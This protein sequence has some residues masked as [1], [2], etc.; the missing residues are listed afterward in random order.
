M[1]INRQEK[2]I[3]IVSF[4]PRTRQGHGKVSEGVGFDTQ[5]WRTIKTGSQST[6]SLRNS[7]ELFGILGLI[8]SRNAVSPTL[9]AELAPQLQF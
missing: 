7:K 2:P 6:F 8:K 4:N 5:P 9:W 1:I 3:L